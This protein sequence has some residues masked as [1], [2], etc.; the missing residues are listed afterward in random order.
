MVMIVLVVMIVDNDGIVIIIMVIMLIRCHNAPT[1]RQRV[2]VLLLEGNGS[3][4]KE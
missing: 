2:M 4:V 1:W 3:G